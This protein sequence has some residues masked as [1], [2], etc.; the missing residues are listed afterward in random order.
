MDDLISR[1]AAID[2]IMQMVENHKS[3]F[4]GGQLLHYTGIKAA[5]ECLPAVDAEPIVRCR[6]CKYGC[7]TCVSD[8]NGMKDAYICEAESLS[9]ALLS[10]D[11]F[12]ADGE[13]RESE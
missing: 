2:E 8:P 3:D 12:C 4:F 5:L 9:D 1:A 7:L 10:P 6:E 13:R 11:W